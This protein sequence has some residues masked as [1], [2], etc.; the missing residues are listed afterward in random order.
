MGAIG[1]TILPTYV[2]NTDVRALKNRLNP[3]V[4]ALSNDVAACAGIP[5]AT[6]SAYQSWAAAWTTYYQTEE[7]TIGPFDWG[8]AAAMD[9]GETYEKDLQSWQQ[10]IASGGWNC[11]PTAPLPSGTG[12]ADD[13]THTTIRVV[14]AA[15]IV[16]ALVV[17]VREVM[18]K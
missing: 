2:T 12:A 18:K 4:V 14:A 9:Q 17:G 11:A 15:A 7:A 5:D 10:K 13:S 1:G 3:F 6:R 8:A 16:I